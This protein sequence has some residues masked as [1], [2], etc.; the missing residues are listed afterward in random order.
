MKSQVDFIRV[1]LLGQ[2]LKNKAL[3]WYQ[4]T[5]NTNAGHHWTF[6]E[7]ML[8]LKRH[9]VK[10]AT[11]RDAA[12]R[13]D[14]LN[15]RDRTVTELKKDLERLSQQ[16]IETPTAYDMARRFLQALRPS[17]ASSVIRYGYNPERSDLD[18][19][20]EVAKQVE[21]AEFYE[22]RDE[23]DRQ[24]NSTRSNSKTSTSKSS[25]DKKTSSTTKRTTTSSKTPDK[26]VSFKPKP[27]GNTKQPEC[28]NCKQKGHYST[29]C[30]KKSAGFKKSANIEA[31][32]EEE[33]PQETFAY[34]AEG[35]EEL[36]SDY[37]SAEDENDNSDAD[38]DPD[39]AS[40]DDELSL[41]D[42]CA[43]ACVAGPAMVINDDDQ[44]NNLVAEKSKNESTSN[45]TDWSTMTGYSPSC[46]ENSCLTDKEFKQTPVSEQS[47]F[48]ISNE[49]NSAALRVLTEDDELVLASS[50]VNDLNTEPVAYRQRAT[51]DQAPRRIEDGPKRDFKRLGV[52]EGYMRINGQKAHVLLDGGSTLDMISANFATLHKLDMFQLKKPIKLQ[53]ATTGSRSVINFG[54]NAEIQIGRFKQNRYFDVINLDRYHVILGTPFLKEHGVMLNY[55]N[56]GSFRLGN[57]WFPVKDGEFS[58]PFSKDEES[59]PSSSR[60]IDIKSELPTNKTNE[61][62]TN[63]R[64]DSKFHSKPTSKLKS[65]AH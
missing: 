11:S 36:S 60:K 65:K 10:D 24:R 14:R 50:K 8:A 39:P 21:Q 22:K 56:N 44:E 59:E 25:G 16:M 55:A 17:I 61:S 37:A 34:A 9:F 20:F 26:G 2:A 3:R 12:I 42:W 46:T 53:M 64:E 5:I 7:A 30:P 52:I 54:V 13:F 62:S 19:I 31:L 40:N 4:H 27:A 29:N 43:Q 51:K 23:L 38:L 18:T 1:D 41:N 45:L 63:K 49:V 48:V 57:V 6:E 28:F 33:E 15:Q 35:E 32:Q 47:H 58:K